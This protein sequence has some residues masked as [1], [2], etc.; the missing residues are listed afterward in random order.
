MNYWNWHYIISFVLRALSFLGFRIQGFGF[1]ECVLRPRSIAI[2]LSYLLNLKKEV[3]ILNVAQTIHTLS[4][5]VAVIRCSE[6]PVYLYI[7]R[8]P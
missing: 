7:S 6:Q 5:P 8:I 4:T 1:L 3:P 2:L